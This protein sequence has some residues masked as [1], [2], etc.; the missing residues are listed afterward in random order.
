MYLFLAILFIIIELLIVIG[1]VVLFIRLKDFRKRFPEIR[2]QILAE[3]I[4]I[5]KEFELLNKKL[6]RPP[7]KPF[8]PY[9][10]GQILGNLTIK[11][12][13]FRRMSVIHLFFTLINMRGRLMATAFK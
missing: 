1:L 7:A 4:T 5:R 2:E 10:L 11:M 3:I 6:E 12:L 13:I 9:E 8:S